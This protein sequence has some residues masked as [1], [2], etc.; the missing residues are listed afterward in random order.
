[1]FIVVRH[2]RTRSNAA[3]LFLG[4]ADPPLDVRGEAQADAVAAALEG[5]SRVVT[6]PLQRAVQTAERIAAR[7]GVPVEVDRRFIELDYGEWD[8]RPLADVD[9]GEW[10]AW[11]SDLAFAPPGGE[12]LHALGERVRAGLDDLVESARRSDVVIV[13]HVS[14]LKAAIAWSL[15]VGDEVAWRM[16]VEPAAICRID[17]GRGIPSLHSFGERA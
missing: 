3:G 5:A 10:A 6:S 1:M 15:G 7:S 16:F 12:S 2:G 14:P 4:H 13:T 8:E 9:P 17:V 11:R